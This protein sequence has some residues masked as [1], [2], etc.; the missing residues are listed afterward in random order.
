MMQN[1][2]VRQDTVE[3]H[4]G[5]GGQLLLVTHLGTYWGWPADIECNANDAQLRWEWGECN[6]RQ[7]LLRNMRKW[8]M[9]FTKSDVVLTDMVSIYVLDLSIN[10]ANIISL[11]KIYFP[12]HSVLKSSLWVN[13]CHCPH[14]VVEK[15]L[16]EKL[17]IFPEVSYQGRWASSQVGCGL[18]VSYLI[19]PAANWVIF[20]HGITFS[21]LQNSP[22]FLWV[23][24]KEI[25]SEN[26]I[27]VKLCESALYSNKAETQKSSSRSLMMIKIVSVLLDYC[28]EIK[29]KPVQY[30]S[31]H[32]TNL[33]MIL[34]LYNDY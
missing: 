15:A 3:E 16:L 30:C 31:W 19:I 18:C 34:D 4:R 24:S 25:F 29:V 32:I 33:C 6:S 10:G 28:K 27:F 14:S 20:S 22:T 5:Q 2:E 8:L 7:G 23:S 9:S 11:R 12:N 21:Y 26:S 13:F 17:R 1:S